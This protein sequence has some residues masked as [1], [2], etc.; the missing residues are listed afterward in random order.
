M[1]RHFDTRRCSTSPTAMG[2]WPPL[3]FLQARSVAPQKLKWGMMGGGARPAAREL[4]NFVREAST[5]FAWSGEGHPTASRRWLGRKP[6]GPGA[7]PLGND[8]TAFWTVDSVTV[9]EG[10][11]DQGAVLEE[12]FGGVLRASPA[13]LQRMEWPDH[14]N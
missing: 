3:L 7:E 1:A 12:S 6:D 9:A 2:Q 14:Q 4:T 8:L 5:R 11:Q 13:S 10:A